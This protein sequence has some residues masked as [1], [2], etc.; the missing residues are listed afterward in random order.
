MQKSISCSQKVAWKIAII[1]I[2]STV[3]YIFI[4]DSIL[5]KLNI[6]DTLWI[7][8]GKAVFFTFVTGFLLYKLI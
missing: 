7:S 3:V 6:L 5:S 1:Y 2:L 8:I 4:T